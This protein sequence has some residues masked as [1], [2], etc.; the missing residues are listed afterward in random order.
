M[1]SKSSTVYDASWAGGRLVLR[2]FLSFRGA[3]FPFLYLVFYATLFTN[4]H[5]SSTSLGCF[6]AFEM[7]I[8]LMKMLSRFYIF[9]V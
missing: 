6:Y 2:P 1:V 4:Y 7:T 5:A 8:F 3:M 9:L